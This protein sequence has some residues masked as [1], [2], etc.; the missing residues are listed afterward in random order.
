MLKMKICFRKFRYFA[1]KKPMI[2]YIY[3]L[4]RTNI[5]LLLI[6]NSKR[7]K[8]LEK[9]PINKLTLVVVKIVLNIFVLV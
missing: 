1:F 8:Y 6:L 7:V 3:P 2:S 9:R 5:I 4:E